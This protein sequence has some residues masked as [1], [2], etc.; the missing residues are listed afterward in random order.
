MNA[1]KLL[2]LLAYGMLAVG[3][4]GCSPEKPATPGSMAL[5]DQVKGESYRLEHAYLVAIHVPN[6]NVDKVLQSVLMAV[7]L[8]YG[9]FDQVAYLD[10]S[11]VERFRPRSG[12]KAGAQGEA[13]RVP[14]TNVSFSVPHDAAVLRKALDAAYKAHSYE[15]PVIYI[16]EVWRTRAI[17][18]DDTNP[19]RWWNNSH[20]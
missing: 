18:P 5:S 20:Q 6:A 17:N 8:D 15:E 14:T 10:A 16:S 1:S 9:K 3:L 13:S 12:S 2:G 4:I 11:G 7:G 19:N